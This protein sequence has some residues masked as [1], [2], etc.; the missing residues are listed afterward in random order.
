MIRNSIKIVAVLLLIVIA[1]PTLIVSAHATITAGNY[2]IEYGWLNEPPI[3]GQA[4]AVVINIST[5]DSSGNGS[6]PAADVDMTN[7]KIEAVYGDQSKVLTL[8]PLGEDTPGQFIAPLTPTRPGTFT[9][10]LS[11]AVG[12]TPVSAEVQPEEIQTA[13]LVQFPRLDTSQGS[14]TSQAF[15]FSGW[16]GLAGV[17]LGALG[18]VLGLVAL[19]RKKA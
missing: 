14:S 17:I 4:N 15:G 11:G 5:R 9:L 3:V 2:D 16:L 7:F 18:T 6:T 12:N 8:Q 13:D 10:R 1:Y 19:N